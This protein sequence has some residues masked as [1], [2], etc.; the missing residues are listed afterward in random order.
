M[1][2]EQLE[3][4]QIVLC[5]VQKIIGTTVFMKIQGNGEG[6]LI[7][8]EIAPGR[9]RNLRA[10]VVPGKKIVCKVLRIKENNVYLSLRRVK[11]N[12]R[13]E[14]LDKIK[15]EK[16]YQAILKTVLGKEKAEKITEKIINQ[17]SIFDFFEEI[18]ENPKSL[19]KFT[20]KT[21]S[22]KIIKILE[23]KKEKP[24]QLKQIFTLSSKAEN[25]INIIKEIIKN[26]SENSEAELSY[27]A[28]GKYRIT[29]TGPEF[30]ELKTKS[31]E[32]LQSLEKQAKKK[33]CMF[34]MM[35]N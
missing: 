9:I 35:K 29:L 31:N 21:E 32:I 16:N 14:L 1:D 27:L 12:E 34:S 33:N 7:T 5:E 18:K 3:E 4:G 8:S 24:K 28:A 11:Q 20:S 10:Y 25:G 17:Q 19:E 23:S 30:K 6:T 22:E 13:K 26:A 2:N 15:K